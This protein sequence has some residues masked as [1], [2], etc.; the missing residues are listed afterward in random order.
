M[1]I[2]ME[3]QVNNEMETGVLYGGRLGYNGKANGQE[4][5]GKWTMT[6]NMKRKLWFYR[7]LENA[8]RPR[9]GTPNST[10]PPSET[11][12]SGLMGPH[13]MLC[14]TDPIQAAA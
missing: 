10:C 12:L 7:V 1:E 11:A 9:P 4:C 8:H 6:W 14:R 5:N 13:T 3:K 2:Q